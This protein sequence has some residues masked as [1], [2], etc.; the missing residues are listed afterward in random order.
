MMLQAL[1]QGRTEAHD[2]SQGAW[3]LTHSDQQAKL[4][5]LAHH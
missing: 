3:Q 5:A 2:T 4:S 1:H